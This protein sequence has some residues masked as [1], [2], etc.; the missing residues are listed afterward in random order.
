MVSVGIGHCEDVSPAL[1]D[2]QIQSMALPT[3]ISIPL[4]GRGDGGS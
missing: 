4:H 2:F 3:V 1:H